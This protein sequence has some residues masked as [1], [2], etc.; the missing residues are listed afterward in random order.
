MTTAGNSEATPAVN[1]PAPPER[2]PRR[3]P[4]KRASSEEPLRCVS[5]GRA[6]VDRLAS[7][8]G[9]GRASGTVRTAHAPIP[10]QTSPEIEVA[11]WEVKARTPKPRRIPAA[12][13]PVAVR[14]S[15]SAALRPWNSEGTPPS[16][17]TS[18]PPYHRAS[19]PPRTPRRVSRGGWSS[20]RGT[21]YRLTRCAASSAMVPATRVD[22]PSA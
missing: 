20:S 11:V 10:A 8:G 3:R 9:L 7:R 13:V 1:R 16:H 5:S 19:I 6:P 17:S 22:D 12:A 14:R 18:S 15:T 4:T 2:R 21:R